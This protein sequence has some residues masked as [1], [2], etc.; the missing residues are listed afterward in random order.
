M[1]SI[2]ISYRRADSQATTDRIYEHLGRDFGSEN[3]FE[4]V[5]QLPAGADF[6]EELTRQITL[7]DV[8]LVIIGQQWASITHEEGEKAGTPRLLDP[9]DYVRI[10]IEAGLA[11]EDMLVIPV[12]VDDANMPT[13]AEL[14]PDLRELQFRNAV[15]IRHNP[16]F[17]D[18]TCRLVDQIKKATGA[19]RN[20][21]K[22]WLGLGIVF[23]MVIVGG[24]ALVMTGAFNNPAASG[25]ATLNVVT[26]PQIEPF[27]PDQTGVLIAQIE[28][29]GGEERDVQRFIVD[30]LKQ[31]FEEDIPFSRIPIRAY[32]AIITSDDQAR[33]VAEQ[34]AATAIIWG[35]YDENRVELEVQVGDLTPYTD[36]PFTRQA[37]EEMVNVRVRMRD[38]R[39]QTLA[40]AVVAAMNGLVTFTGDNVSQIARNMAVLEQIDVPAADPVGN[41][42]AAHYHR[43]ILDYIDD[44]EGAISHLSAAIRL[45]A[46]QPALY[47]AR[48][49]GYQRLG[50]IDEARTDALTARRIGPGDWYAPAMNLSNI[51]F[52]LE[53]DV[54]NALLYAD[55][56]LRIIPDDWFAQTLR[57]MFHYFQG[58]YEQA[59]VD[60]EQALTLRPEANYPYIFAV[61]IALR[62][63]RLADAQVLLD[64]VL[65][66]FPDPQSAERAISVTLNEDAARNNIIPLIAGFGN[67]TLRR[68]N[69]VIAVTGPALADGAELSDFGVLQGIA[70]CNLGDYAAAEAA[71][72]PGIELDPDFTWLYALR[73]EV[74]QKQGN[75]LGALADGAFVLGSDLAEAFA[76]LIPLIQSGEINCENMFDVDLAA[77]LSAENS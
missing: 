57:A 20:I 33:M 23:V 11:R 65:E 14:P 28:H 77:L 41:S 49:L 9:D 42:I 25:D 2:F 54:D 48:S 15:K 73:A 76:P 51:A 37:I 1:P 60:V 16:Y 66:Q 22:W 62:Q 29:I 4:D 55:E 3:V 30:D 40:H 58:N 56:T 50:L 34:A 18:D 31:H 21:P 53:G 70:Y 52:Y 10:E 7:R 64:T 32:P 35:N 24:L 67:L 8:M 5:E 39:T 19:E 61:S 45:D 43:F 38:E 46:G 13:E 59:R 72:S 71:Y 44:I 68:W 75:M 6:R 36:L 27:L 47:T 74:R 63:G 17:N 69:D 12:L 26:L